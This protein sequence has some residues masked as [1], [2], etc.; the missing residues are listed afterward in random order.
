MVAPLLLLCFALLLPATT[1]RAAD[2]TNSSPPATAPKSPADIEGSP[3]WV[4]KMLLQNDPEALVNLG[5]KYL[6]GNSVSED[7]K[8][9]VQMFFSAA[10][11]GDSRAECCLGFAFATGAGGLPKDSLKARDWYQVSAQDDYPEAQSYLGRS[12]WIGQ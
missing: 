4:K 7:G 5:V 3:E 12:L 1:S 11:W 2:S 9:A 8:K 10:A 6:G